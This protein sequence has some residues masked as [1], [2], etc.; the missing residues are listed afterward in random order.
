MTAFATATDLANR[1]GLTLTTDEVA[2][3]TALLADASKNVIDAT[4]QDILLVDDDEYERPGTRDRRIL[5]PQ[6]PVVSVASV[7]IDDVEVSDWYLVGSE[8][9]RG[10]RSSSLLLDSLI[11]GCG[12]SWGEESQTLTITYTHG[13]A[14]DALPGIVKNFTLEQVVRV[15]VNPGSVIQESEGDTQVIYAPFAAPPAGLALTNSEIS[16]LKRFFGVRASSVQVD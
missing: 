3:A 2:R 5:L 6:R 15:W 13:Y 1:L 4:G 9:V 14:A 7:K 10:S 16:K 11:D 8:L 12:W